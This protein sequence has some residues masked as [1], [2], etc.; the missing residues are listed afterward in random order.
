[1]PKNSRVNFLKNVK[2]ISVSP[3]EEDQTALE[4]IFAR[5]PWPLCPDSTWDLQAVPGLSTALPVLRR[6]PPA[7]V[8]CE[9][10]LG[11]CTWREM[12]AHV[13]DLPQPPFL[14]VTSRHADDRLWA[15]ALNLGAYDVLAKPFDAS[16]VVRTLSMAWLYWNHRLSVEAR[17]TAT[18]W[19]PMG[20]RA[21]VSV[22]V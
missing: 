8:L 9:R 15:E 1:M 3:C 20:L 16:E 14:I 22:A 7:L 2:V 5:A 13:C 18:A 19:P 11:D 21:K 10:D 6:D 17:R 4:R 12:L